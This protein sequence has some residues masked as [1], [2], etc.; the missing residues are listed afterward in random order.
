MFCDQ[1]CPLENSNL[2]E[3]LL[4]VWNALLDRA[5]LDFLAYLIYFT[6]P[7]KC[8]WISHFFYYLSE[9]SWNFLFDQ[10]VNHPFQMK[11]VSEEFS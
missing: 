9:D 11:K 3:G 7:H 5:Y 2:P 10:K 4:I 6:F 8:K 1:I